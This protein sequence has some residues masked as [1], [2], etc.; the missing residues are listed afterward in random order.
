MEKIIAFSNKTEARDKFTKAIQYSAKIIAWSVLNVDK[1]YY[2]R[3]N[4]LYLMAR[5]SRKIFR[6]FKSVQ[7]I[8]TINDKIKDLLW[9]SEKFPTLCE[10]CSRIGFL[11]YWVSDNFFILSSVKMLY[12]GDMYNFSY[13]AHLGWLIG[14][15]WALVKNLYELIILLASK[16]SEKIEREGEG[17]NINSQNIRKREIFMNLICIIGKL[18][19]LLPASSGV[20]IPERILGYHLSDGVIWTKIT[21]VPKY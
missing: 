5:D 21:I 8:K 11:I 2:K 12:V 14:I 18:G 17:G 9:K 20:N 3:F 1:S 4:D 15:L 7:E 19:D 6:L 13:I 16:E 10:I